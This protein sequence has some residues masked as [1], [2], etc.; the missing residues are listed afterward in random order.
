MEP[1]EQINFLT[2]I[3]KYNRLHEKYC[4]AFS[5]AKGDF[6][7]MFQGMAE[8]SCYCWLDKDNVAEEGKGFASY[9]IE[10]KTLG[11]VGYKNRHYAYLLLL[12]EHPD[13]SPNHEDPNYWGKSYYIV[14]V[15]VQTPTE[16]TE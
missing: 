10:S 6:A 5:T 16:S 13:L 12:K 8:K 3:I 2:Q 14:E 9:H 15:T 4:A 7:N 1:Q 11:T